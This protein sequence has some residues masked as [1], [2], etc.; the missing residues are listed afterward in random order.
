MKGTLNLVLNKAITIENFK[1]NLADYRN[2]IYQFLG[3][4]CAL[5]GMS[6]Y[7]SIIDQRR[8]ISRVS[9][10]TNNPR[11]FDKRMQP[12]GRDKKKRAVCVRVC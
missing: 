12:F 2:N 6:V 7:M 10:A 11:Q 1:Q 5:I 9:S 4:G 8:V 3:L